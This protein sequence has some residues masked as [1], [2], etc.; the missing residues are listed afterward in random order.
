VRGFTRGGFVRFAQAGGFFSV[1]AV[2]GANFYPFPPF[3]ARPLARA[4][5]TFAVSLFFLC[6]RT[7]REGSF[8]QVLD[9]QPFETPYFRG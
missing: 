4:L 2:R 9:E 8:L 6:A 7:E 1:R 5:P 3:L